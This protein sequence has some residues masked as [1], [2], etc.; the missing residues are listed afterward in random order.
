MSRGSIGQIAAEY[1]LGDFPSQTVKWLHYDRLGSVMN[2]SG[3]A[4]TLTDTYHQDA[5]GNVIS[6][7]TTGQWASSMS[8]RHLTT[9]EYD[10][11]ANLYYFWQRWYDPQVGRFVGRDP[12]RGRCR[13]HD[14]RFSRNAPTN[15][16]DADGLRDWLFG[17][18]ELC[19]DENCDKDK[20]RCRAKNKKEDLHELDD[21]PDP[22]QC[23]DSDGIYTKKAVLQIRNNCKC[24]IKCDEDGAPD[25]ISCICSPWYPWPIK[26]PPNKPPKGWPDNPFVEQ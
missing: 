1:T 2:K 6:N 10:D 26:H 20:V 21:V 15:S 23:K 25:H 18:G 9:K 8:G 16:I 17:A 7:I 11:D 4:G 24:T 12:A 13:G 3:S 5:Y 22:G 19:T 14:Y